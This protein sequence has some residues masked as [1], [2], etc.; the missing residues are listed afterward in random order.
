MT[1]K[2]DIDTLNL[3][4]HDYAAHFLLPTIWSKSDPKVAAGG[5]EWV[6]QNFYNATFKDEFDYLLEAF[7]ETLGP[8]V[9]PDFD[10]EAAKRFTPR[11]DETFE[12]LLAEKLAIM[13]S[14]EHIPGRV[15]TVQVNGAR[16]IGQHL[17]EGPAFGEFQSQ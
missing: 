6:L 12:Q 1:R 3:A 17:I 8:R 10:A 13:P 16:I 2:L 7:R 14:G 11:S 5:R 4:A 9:L 15:G